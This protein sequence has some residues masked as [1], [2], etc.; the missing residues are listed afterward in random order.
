MVEG[1]QLHVSILKPDTPDTKEFKIELA[2]CEHEPSD[3]KAWFECIKEEENGII[4]KLVI[5]L[6]KF[7]ECKPEYRLFVYPPEPVSS[8]EVRHASCRIGYTEPKLNLDVTGTDFLQ[9]V[10]LNKNPEGVKPLSELELKQTPGTAVFNFTNVQ[11][12]SEK[13]DHIENPSYFFGCALYD[14]RQLQ[15]LY[16]QGPNGKNEE[17]LR[18]A[19]HYMCNYNP[20]SLPF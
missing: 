5:R 15:G 8:V 4:K 18:K 12:N 3:P 6:H 19:H 9:F 20:E 1:G 10:F 17:P 16:L 14:Y 2:D 7:A 11:S 13:L